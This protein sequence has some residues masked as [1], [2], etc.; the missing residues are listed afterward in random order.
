M[1][2]PQPARRPGQH[3][4]MAGR[5]VRFAL[6]LI[7]VA[8]AGCSTGDSRSP[9]TSARTAAGSVIPAPPVPLDQ[10]PEQ[11]AAGDYYFVVHRENSLNWRSMAAYSFKEKQWRKLPTP[12]DFRDQS[13]TWDGTNL[14]LVGLR[15]CDREEG[16]RCTEGTPTAAFIEPSSGDWRIVDLGIGEIDVSPEVG[17]GLSTI[18]G[19]EGAVYLVGEAGVQRMARNG[20]LVT[21]AEPPATLRWTPCLTEAGLVAASSHPAD[22]VTVTPLTPGNTMLWKLPYDFAEG[23]SWQPVP[24]ETPPISEPDA[25][26][27][28]GCDGAGVVLLDV[29]NERALTWAPG[30][31]SWTLADDL[32]NGPPYHDIALNLRA[33]ASGD[34][35][36][37]ERIQS[38]QYVYRLRLNPAVGSPAWSRQRAEWARIDIVGDRVLAYPDQRANPQD[39]QTWRLVELAF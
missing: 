4:D 20:K 25:E 36:G 29:I 16:I 12:P 33:T 39:R 13:Q 34:L 18:L 38:G 8:A 28:A 5:L 37:H 23:A 6:L 17:W 26:A 10:H 14:V 30:A 31:S 9:A 35:V 24:A 27:R 15:G 32:V 21:S 2:R 3:C 7:L 1:T 11:F 22:D 19:H